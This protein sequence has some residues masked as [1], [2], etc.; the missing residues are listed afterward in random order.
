MNK[1]IVLAAV[2]LGWAAAACGDDAAIPKTH[3]DSAGWANLLAKDLSDATYPKG[4]WYFEGDV[5]TATKDQNIWTQKEY[6][7]CIIDLEFKNEP[8][9]NS[10]VIVYASDLQSWIPN[11]VEIQI[12]D[13]FAAKWAKSPKS[14]QCAAA[15]GHQAPTKSMV[16]KSGEWNR[17]TITC[18]GSN[19]YVILNGEQVTQIDMKKWT[20]AKTN[21]DG[22]SIPG[23]LSKPLAEIPTKGHVG[24]QGKHGGVPIYFRNLKIKTLD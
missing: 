4:V 9:T 2:C 6:G 1:T 18:M 8:G 14:F 11:S 3:P 22:T 13:D 5:L 16:K 20:S 15:F 12:A 17:M 23:W 10:G 19:I 21:P 24:L 7:N